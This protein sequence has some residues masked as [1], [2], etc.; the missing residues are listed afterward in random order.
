MTD[1]STFNWANVDNKNN[2]KHK[3]YINTDLAF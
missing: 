2:L 1:I 3:L